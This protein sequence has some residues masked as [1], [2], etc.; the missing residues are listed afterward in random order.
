MT[1]TVEKKTCEE[2]ASRLSLPLRLP[3]F[4][5]PG[6]VLMPR[7]TLPLNVFEPRYLAMVDDALRADRL[8]GM[9]QPAGNA[10]QTVGCA[11]RITAFEET[12][13]GR[14]LIV[15]TGL[16][17]FNIRHEEALAQGGYRVV[18]PDWDGFSEDLAPIND[19]GVCRE[20]MLE[21]LRP[22]LAKMEMSCDQWEAMRAVSCDTLVSTLMMICPFRD[23][24][25]QMLLAAKTLPER[26]T[27]L[28]VFLE[29]ALIDE[30]DQRPH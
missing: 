6:V 16:C 10:L 15:L 19:G 20:A 11:G 27:I 12:D 17:R 18:A 28:R 4:P 24:E 2:R 7:V 26:M 8:I 5:L 9:V 21:T 23:D 25:K 30:K 1:D 29:K 3:V 13:D 22:Y 14:Y